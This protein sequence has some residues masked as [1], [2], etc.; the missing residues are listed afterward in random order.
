MANPRRPSYSA[1][2]GP[3]ISLEGAQAS[4]A[5]LAQRSAFSSSSLVHFL[6]KPLAFPFLLSAFLLLTWIS[7]RLQSSSSA[8]R[9]AS[10][11][12]SE[13]SR[14]ED[15]RKANLVRFPLGSFS[16]K[17]GWLLDPTSV[18]LDSGIR[19]GAVACAS[20]HVGEIRPG[21]VRANHRHHTCNET[22]VIWGAK[23]KFR[24]AHSSTP[25]TSRKING[26]IVRVLCSINGCYWKLELFKLESSELGGKTYAEVVVAAD[27]VAVAASPSGTAHALVNIDPVHSTFFIGCQDGVINYNSSSTDYRVWKD[28]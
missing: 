22:F 24:G 7:L 28:L 4:P 8:S 13:R 2:G 1:A 5:A 16:D 12:D 20:I 17:R 3:A 27:E 10:S 25:S 15:D 23:T 19:G 11:R 9:F 6:K 14:E 26:I 18:A 21:G